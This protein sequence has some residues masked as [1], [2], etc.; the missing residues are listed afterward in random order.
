MNI[1]EAVKLA[2]EGKKVFRNTEMVQNRAKQG[3]PNT[4]VYS[5]LLENGNKALFSSFI[6]GNG[7]RSPDFYAEDILAN[8]WEVVDE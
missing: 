8:D 7:G 4:Y 1:I 2:F 5:S 3:L 6:S